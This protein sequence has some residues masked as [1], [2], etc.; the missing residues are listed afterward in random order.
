MDK[1]IIIIPIAVIIGIIIF[2]SFSS[3]NQ[4]EQI[5]E[6]II[7]EKTL[8][9]DEEEIKTDEEIFKEI[10]EKYKEIEEKS[11]ES[12]YIPKDRVWQSSGPFKIDRYEYVLGE[13]IFM[14][15][16]NLRVDEKGE[17]V[18]LRFLNQ[19]HLKVWQTF[20]FDGNDKPTFNIY[21]EPRISKTF[22]ICDK[23]DL[24]GEW[25]VNFRGTK[26]TDLRFSI[27]E[28][29][30]PGDELDFSERVC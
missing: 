18:L 10:E 21:F 12:E 26:Y 17:I 20:P 1:K 2:A 25:I 28:Q 3:T 4:D 19:T 8:A 6:K 22:E 5:D 11:T 15:I 24:I 29:V 7:I 13:K 9:I 14:Q 23:D 30:L 16:E 27:T